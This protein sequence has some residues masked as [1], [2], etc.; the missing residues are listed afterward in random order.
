MFPVD[1]YDTPGT[2]SDAARSAGSARTI[3]IVAL[4]VA[5][6][7]PFWEESVLGSINIHLPMARELAQTTAAVDRLDR[8][9][10]ALEQQLSAATAQVGKLQAALAQTTGRANTAADW[11]GMVAMTDLA[12]ALRRPGGFD[13]ELAT[14]RA[15]TPSSSRC[16]GPRRRSRNRGPSA[17]RR[18]GRTRKT[19]RPAAVRGS[20]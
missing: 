4:I 13:L 10:A 18:G 15:A 3:A 5:L 6:T 20:V 2:G 16:R 11:V 9:T 14:L 12:V 7:A 8:K 1:Q 19:A 17:P